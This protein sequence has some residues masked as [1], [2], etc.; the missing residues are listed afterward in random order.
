MK[1]KGTWGMILKVIIAIATSIAGV[2]G[3]SSCVG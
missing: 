1:S 2:V 3:I